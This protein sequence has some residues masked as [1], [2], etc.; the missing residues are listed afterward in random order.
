MA[1]WG[2]RE[3][4]WENYSQTLLIIASLGTIGYWFVRWEW[5]L[6]CLLGLILLITLVHGIARFFHRLEKYFYKGGRR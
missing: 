2:M 3:H 1:R 5:L 4:K 6:Y